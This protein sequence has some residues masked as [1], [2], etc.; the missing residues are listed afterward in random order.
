MLCDLY[1]NL[2]I[3]IQ[4]CGKDNTTL[5]LTGTFKRSQGTHYNR[6]SVKD[7]FLSTSKAHCS[8]FSVLV[9]LCNS[10]DPSPFSVSSSFLCSPSLYR[11]YLEP[12][13]TNASYQFFIYYS[14]FNYTIACSMGD[15][16]ALQLKDSGK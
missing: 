14:Y 12:S 6:I 10:A 1:V 16:G 2:T 8:P 13:D 9:P 3:H 11:M 5:S 7:A 15:S 4:D